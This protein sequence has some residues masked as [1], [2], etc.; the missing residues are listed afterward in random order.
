LCP[1]IEIEKEKFLK[2][3]EEEIDDSEI[4]LDL[5]LQKDYF[6]EQE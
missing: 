5:I 2:C 1:Q 4:N 6:I 3:E